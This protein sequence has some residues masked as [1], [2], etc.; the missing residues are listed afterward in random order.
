MA[1]RHFPPATDKHAPDR[2]WWA[3][4]DARENFA[5]AAQREAPRMAKSRIGQNHDVPILAMPR[6]GWVS[7]YAV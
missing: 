3:A 4:P 1:D 7:P 2:S 5:A 6:K